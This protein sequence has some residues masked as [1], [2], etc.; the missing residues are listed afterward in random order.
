MSLPKSFGSAFTLALA[1]LLFFDLVSCVSPK[2]NVTVQQQVDEG[3]F[4]GH[5]T[6][7]LSKEGCPYL[8]QYKEGKEDKFLIPVQLED[9]FK[10]NG[11][12]VKFKFHYS[13]IKQGECQMGQPAVLEFI[14]FY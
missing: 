14:E 4:V 1:A 3:F 2:S 5:I 12:K 7:E 8:L 11:L 10:Q 13:R 9:K 6:S